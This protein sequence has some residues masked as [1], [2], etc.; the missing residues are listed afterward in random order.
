MNIRIVALLFGIAFVAG[1]LAWYLPAFFDS[2]GLLLG[3]FLVDSFHNK[4]HL[5]SGLIGLAAA[6]TSGYWSKL[7]FKLFGAIYGLLGVV[8]LIFP[9]DFMSMQMNMADNL[10]HIGIG[11]LALLIGFRMK[12]PAGE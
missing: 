7:Y 12:I 9:E 5:V 1:G 4:V 2:N 6:A 11:V 10:L 8:G 3:L